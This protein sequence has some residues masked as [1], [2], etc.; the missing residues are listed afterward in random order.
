M[1]YWDKFSGIVLSSNYL[2]SFVWI[3]GRLVLSFDY[4]VQ[5]VIDINCSIHYGQK[6]STPCGMP[7]KT[8][9]DSAGAKFT[10][11]GSSL[12]SNLLQ[13][14]YTFINEVSDWSLD[15]PNK[16]RCY[17]LN[18]LQQKY[19]T[20]FKDA[21]WPAW[22]KGFEVPVTI[23]KY[24]NGIFC[25]FLSHSISHSLSKSLIVKR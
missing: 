15:F 14:K 17:C 2:N 19:K 11:S 23:L 5:S 21:F 3:E 12:Y 7:S 20:T 22:C 8:V 10:L 1:L 24:G 9:H 16:L 13:K 18:E 4:F 25:P 6:F